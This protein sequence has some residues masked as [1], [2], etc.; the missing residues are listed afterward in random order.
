MRRIE[1]A[2]LEEEQFLVLL[3]DHLRA[4]SALGHRRAFIRTALVIMRAGDCGRPA[5]PTPHTC[6]P[7]RESMRNGG[8]SP[9]VPLVVD[10]PLTAASRREFLRVLGLGSAIVLMPSM[11]A[12]CSDA[13]GVTRGR[14]AAVTLDLSA[15]GYSFNF[16]PVAGQTFT[17]SGSGTCH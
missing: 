6:W 13:T 12:A 1:D 2:E 3:H 4:M 7:W 11:F 5:W 14:N 15:T 10:R 9:G 8:G 17:D 16:V